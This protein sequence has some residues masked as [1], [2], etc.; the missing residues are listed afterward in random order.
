MIRV[1]AERLDVAT[2]AEGDRFRAIFADE[3]LRLGDRATASA[4]LLKER[5]DAEIATLAELSRHVN[6]RADET[7]QLMR[8]ESERL[9]ATPPASRRI[10]APPSPPRASASTSARRRRRNY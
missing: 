1:E 6:S 8:A 9:G 5:I 4:A 7:D 2:N 3:S 10:S